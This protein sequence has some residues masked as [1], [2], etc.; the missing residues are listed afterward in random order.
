MPTAWLSAAAAAAAA[1]K[2]YID[3]HL[4][5]NYTT[6]THTLI[7]TAYFRRPSCQQGFV[8][9]FREDIN[10]IGTRLTRSSSR[11]LCA[12]QNPSSRYSNRVFVVCETTGL[13]RYPCFPVFFFFFCSS[14][15]HYYTGY[16]QP[17]K[18]TREIGRCAFLF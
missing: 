1:A 7:T 6:Q 16:V 10:F 3:I 5:V 4:P 2:N 14:I 17:E 13:R 11:V 8:Y 15:I 12:A 18:D 9:F